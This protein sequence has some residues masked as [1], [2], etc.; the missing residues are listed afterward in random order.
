MV[1]STQLFKS[2]V[3][4]LGIH[5]IGISEL[6][7]QYQKSILVTVGSSK[8]KASRCFC[9][10]NVLKKNEVEISISTLT[11]QNSDFFI[12]QYRTRSKLEQMH[13][14]IGVA[15]RCCI[16]ECIETLKSFMKLSSELP[17]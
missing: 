5:F 3:F 10:R 4:T 17:S 2:D 1:N 16:M 8:V 7:E 15:F 11:Y 12:N 13:D 9:I 14:C 6:R